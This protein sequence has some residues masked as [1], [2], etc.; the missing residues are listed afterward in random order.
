MTRKTDL[1]L[2]MTRYAAGDD[3]AFAAIHER[4][5]PILRAQ[6][7]RKVADA[8]MADELLQ[9]AFVKAHLARERF[10]LEGDDGE[11]AVVVWYTAIARNAT[12]DHLRRRY[13]ARAFEDSSDQ[14]RVIERV[15]DPKLGPEASLIEREREETVRARV[16]E[17]VAELPAGQSAVVRLHKLEDRRV[18]EVAAE[19]GISEGAAR[20]RA[21][22]GYKLLAQ[23][24]GDLAVAA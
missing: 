18:S 4:L 22:R 1:G 24:L 12:T 14:G 21:H 3:R 23:S 20:V 9:L 8:E 7:R 15:F 10:H 6:I 17:A 2:T 5:A 19:L 11:R 16:R 13:R